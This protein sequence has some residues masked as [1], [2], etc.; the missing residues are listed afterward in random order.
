[1][2]FGGNLGTDSITFTLECE[3]LRLNLFLP[4]KPLIEPRFIMMGSNLLL[5]K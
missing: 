4:S 1:M 2:E 3:K 5:I